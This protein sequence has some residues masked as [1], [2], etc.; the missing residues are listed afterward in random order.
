[1]PPPMTSSRSGMP[2]TSS[3]PV[4]SM[5]RSSS[6]R[7][8]SDAASEPAAMMQCSKP[9]TVS[10]T[11]IVFGPVNSPVPRTT[12]TLRCLA[13]DSRPPVSLPTT[14]FFHSR[15]LSTSIFGA[16][17][18]M[19]GLA[20]LGGLGHAPWRRAAAP[21]TGC[22]RRSGRR[23]RA[24]RRGRSGRRS[25]RGRRRGTPPCSRPGR[26]RARRPG[27][28]TS[29]SRRRAAARRSAASSFGSATCSAGASVAGL[30]V[31]GGAPSSVSSTEP[32]ATLS[33]TATVMSVTL[34]AA[35]DGTSI[36][37]LSDSSTTSGSST[38]T[39]SPTATSTSMT[40]TSSKSPMSGTLTSIRAAPFADRR[41][42]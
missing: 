42:G 40:G 39:S 41:A 2:S 27:R 30:A 28:L 35:G 17:N 10:P 34:P 20:E 32:S 7:N 38:A 25:A 21:W 36:V 1:M 24:A 29:A 23:R 18:V 31:L 12:W 8:G 19:P 33:P 16:S 11:S 3:A 15:T 14:P 5:I 22:S 9:T 6:G 26:R 13:S 37:A 4:E